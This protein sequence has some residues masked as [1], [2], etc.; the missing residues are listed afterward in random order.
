MPV[1]SKPLK[2][3]NFR[4]ANW[5]RYRSITNRLAKHLPPLCAKNINAAY[6]DF[7]KLIITAAKQTIP[8]GKRK[9]YIP[10]WDAEC[11]SLFQ[12]FIQSPP[13][14]ES[15]GAASALLDRLD[16]KRREKWNEAVQS[17]DFT[18]SSRKAWNII[19]NLTGRSRQRPGHCPVSANSIAAQ[20]VKKCDIPG[21]RPQIVQ[22]CG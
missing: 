15:N 14:A 17:I 4:K 8:R 11:E 12:V 21:S 9:V 19:N 3:W 7:C 13:G 2:R 20:L 6:H 18:H 5:S 22:T 10:C 1:T 16:K